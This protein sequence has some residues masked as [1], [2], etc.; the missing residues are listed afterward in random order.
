MDT[1]ITLVQ[2]GPTGAGLAFSLLGYWLLFAEQKSAAARPQMLSAIRYFITL[3]VVTFTL[4]LIANLLVLFFNPSTQAFIT[5][6]LNSWE[7]KKD[8][9]AISFSIATNNLDP[10]TISH[11]P[12]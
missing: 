10:P 6:R 9:P 11:D 12:K 4:G 1:L 5:A 8:K 7:A 2:L 3:S